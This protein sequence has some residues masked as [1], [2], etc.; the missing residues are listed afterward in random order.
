MP[1]LLFAL[2]LTAAFSLPVLM[3][4]MLAAFFTKTTTVGFACFFGGSIAFI[5]CYG[6]ELILEARQV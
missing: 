2:R 4:G 1:S 5:L 3:L 6:S